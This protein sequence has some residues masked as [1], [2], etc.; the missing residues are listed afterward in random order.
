MLNLA[1]LDIPIAGVLDEQLAAAT[2]D[3]KPVPTPPRPSRPMSAPAIN[4]PQ[5]AWRRGI[6]IG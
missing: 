5:P 1:E 6:V 2:K 3:M 4:D